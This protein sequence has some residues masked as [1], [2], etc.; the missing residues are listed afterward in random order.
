MVRALREPNLNKV[1][2]FVAGLVLQNHD[3][4]GNPSLVSDDSNGHCV[5]ISETKFDQF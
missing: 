5:L 1:G 4:I 2:L 3:N